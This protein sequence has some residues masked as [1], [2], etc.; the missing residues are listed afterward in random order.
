MPCIQV[1]Y[2]IAGGFIVHSRNVEVVRADVAT[3]LEPDLSRVDNLIVDSSFSE[4]ELH[5]VQSIN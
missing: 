5:S 2:H 3:F 4:I 1:H